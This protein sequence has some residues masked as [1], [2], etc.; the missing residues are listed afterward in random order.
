MRVE[1][2]VHHVEGLF[3]DLGVEKIN[4]CLPLMESVL[5]ERDDKGKPFTRWVVLGCNE[6]DNSRSVVEEASC[7][8]AEDIN[9]LWVRPIFCKFVVAS[10]P[11]DV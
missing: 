10:V 2:L 7:L 1:A 4:A 3:K 5:W 6:F 9:I 11:G 8:V